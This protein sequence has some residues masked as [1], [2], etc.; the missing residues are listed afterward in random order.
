MFEKYFEDYLFT[1]GIPYYVLSG[2]AEYVK[3]L[4]DDIIYKDI[5]ALHNIKNH[6]ILKDFFL[7]LMERAGKQVSLNKAG[8]ILGISI[9]S[10]KRYL[11][12]FTE[13]YL[14]YTISR[15]G[16]ANEQILSPQQIYAADIKLLMQSFKDIEKLKEIT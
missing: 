6:Q 5:A 2:E 16:K 11:A 14:I 1:G 15:H 10:A 8:H 7:L 4:V 3:E 13:C 9:D 12:M